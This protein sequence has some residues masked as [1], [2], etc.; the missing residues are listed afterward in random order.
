VI[1]WADAICMNQ[2]DPL[3][4]NH[5]IKLMTR[6]Y[7][8]AKRVLVWLGPD[9]EGHGEKAFR[10]SRRL[11]TDQLFA[12]DVFESL[13]GTKRLAYE[14]DRYQVV[15]FVIEILIRHWFRRV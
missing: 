10:L 5:Q 12:T 4:R 7:S 1:I 3:E 2:D 15:S 14:D 11:S 6:I 13:A 8:K 9:P